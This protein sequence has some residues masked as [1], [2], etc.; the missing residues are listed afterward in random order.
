MPNTNTICNQIQIICRKS[1]VVDIYLTFIIFMYVSEFL[2]VMVNEDFMNGIGRGR[3]RKPLPD[4]ATLESN[5]RWVAELAKNQVVEK[6]VSEVTGRKIEDSLKD[7][8]NDVWL[9]LLLDDKTTGLCEHN[10]IR[11]YI[12][13]MV[14]NNIASSSSPYRRIYTHYHTLA[15]P[16]TKQIIDTLTDE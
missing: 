11:F 13:R 8:V 1:E 14:M 2:F 10:E 4:E 5:R 6:I 3:R 16:L 12:A 15:Q 7:L 9:W